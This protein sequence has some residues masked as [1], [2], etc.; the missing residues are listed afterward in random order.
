MIWN[1]ELDPAAKAENC[2]KVSQA[3]PG[4]VLLMYQNLG[5]GGADECPE[6]TARDCARFFE[7]CQEW[8]L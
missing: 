4:A 2:L 3:I 8:P 1:G 7:D 5:H 6:L